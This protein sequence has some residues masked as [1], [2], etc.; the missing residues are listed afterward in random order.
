M[1][2]TEDL[3]IKEATQE[4]EKI[5]TRRDELRTVFNLSTELKYER[6]NSEDCIYPIGKNILIRTVTHIQV[7]K[8][9]SVHPQELVLEN[10]SWIADTGRFQSCLEKGIDNIESS[11]IELFPKDKQVLV[12]RGAIIDS[13]EYPNAL[14]TKQK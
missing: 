11:E 5:E 14:P 9:I 1:K 3:T 10:A 4:L 12:G 8:L 7:G 13:C 6:N 2:K